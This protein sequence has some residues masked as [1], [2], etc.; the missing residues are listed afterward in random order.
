LLVILLICWPWIVR[1]VAVPDF[2][3][4]AWACD[5]R[6][7]HVSARSSKQINALTPRSVLS[8]KLSIYALPL[9]FPSSDVFSLYLSCML[10][11]RIFFHPKKLYRVSNTVRITVVPS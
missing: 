2:H 3:G 7:C 9:V 1:R 4:A 5:H 8:P 6:S 10:A 11:I